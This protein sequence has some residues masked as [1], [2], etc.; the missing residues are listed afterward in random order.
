MTP[1]EIGRALGISERAV[2][3]IIG[4]PAEAGKARIRSV[5]RIV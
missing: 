4:M 5:E 1:V 2:C 3:S